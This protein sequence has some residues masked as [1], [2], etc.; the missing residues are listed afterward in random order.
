MEKFK[1]ETLVKLTQMLKKVILA[2]EH[3]IYNRNTM[4]RR[5]WFIESGSIEE[6]TDN[7]NFSR[8][9]KV[10]SVYN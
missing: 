2:P 7:F 10:I 4:D 6:F 8:L 3:V 1:E 9:R 5:L